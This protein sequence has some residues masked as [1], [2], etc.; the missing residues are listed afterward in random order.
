M[1]SPPLHR[2]S[3]RNRAPADHVFHEPFRWPPG[4]GEPQKTHTALPKE[5]CDTDRNE[6]YNQINRLGNIRTKASPYDR[7]AGS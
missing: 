3:A 4:P 7:N 1:A 2:A 5:I 6:S